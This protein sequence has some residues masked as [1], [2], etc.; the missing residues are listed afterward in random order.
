MG[1]SVEGPIRQPLSLRYDAERSKRA[2]RAAALLLRNVVVELLD[3]GPTVARDA[4][5]HVDRDPPRYVSEAEYA[6]TYKVMTPMVQRATDLAVLTGLRSGDLL[7]LTRA[8]LT[9]DGIEVATSKTGKRLLIE[10]WKSFR[11]LFR[12]F[13]E[14]SEGFWS[15]P[16]HAFEFS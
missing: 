7:R 6:A 3:R 10:W 2:A 15:T 9:D 8:N 14:A 16:N 11:K 5:G 4:S 12:S 13:L 1:P